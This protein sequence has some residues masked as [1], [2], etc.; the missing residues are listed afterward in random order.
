MEGVKASYLSNK[1]LI[2]E[3]DAKVILDDAWKSYQD[4]IKEK[5]KKGW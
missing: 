4:K 5:K 3:S 2:S 1:T